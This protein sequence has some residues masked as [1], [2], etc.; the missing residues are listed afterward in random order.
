MGLIA[1]VVSE[2]CRVSRA[3]THKAFGV[4]ANETRHHSMEITAMIQ[5]WEFQM[6][7]RTI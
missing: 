4:S 7:M 1:N 6:T 2:C 5:S 3:T